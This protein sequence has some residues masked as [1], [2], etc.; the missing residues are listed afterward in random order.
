M[1]CVVR[2]KPV[3]LLTAACLAGCHFGVAALDPAPAPADGSAGT[4]SDSGSL[5][6]DGGAPADLT[7]AGD[8]AGDP[9][10][11]PLVPASDAVTAAC[12]IGNPP[13]L[14]GQLGDWSQPMFA[15]HAR[16][17]G[18]ASTFGDWDDDESD[19]DEDLSA[20][21]AL[22]WDET[23]LYLG[24]DVS[25]DQRS[26]S[27]LSFWDNDTVEFY[28]DGQRD[29]SDD[30]G[31]DD[32]EIMVRADGQARF[33]KDG[34]EFTPAHSITVKTADRPGGWTVEVA[35]PWAALGGTPPVLARRLGFTLQLND[36]DNGGFR[37]RGLIWKNAG[38]SSCS[39]CI[40]SCAPWCNTKAFYDLRLGSRP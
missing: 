30:Y 13:V 38:S 32:L 7:A 23:H 37:D 2:M 18:A 11:G 24:F 4:I 33:Y 12:S 21:G 8:L 5:P 20:R 36:N 15:L 22:R 16:H 39:T 6:S 26:V 34:G 1:H 19:N 40:G 14:D 9:C 3:S 35:V 25:D 28:L 10:G 31:S 27:S 17:Q 29:R